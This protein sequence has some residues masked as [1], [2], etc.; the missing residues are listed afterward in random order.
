[1]WTPVGHERF[2]PLLPQH[3]STQFRWL[4]QNR[5][6]F[7]SNTQFLRMSSCLKTLRA[8]HIHSGGGLNRHVGCMMTHAPRREAPRKARSA[9]MRTSSIRRLLRD[10][11]RQERSMDPEQHST[12]DL[13][14]AR[15]MSQEIERI[16]AR[17]SAIHV[18]TLRDETDMGGTR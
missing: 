16:A 11:W 2:S 8:P 14:T 6:P 17:L 18:S 13:I 4:V 9:T 3:T 10:A 7:E 15:R 12:I 1:M 5:Q